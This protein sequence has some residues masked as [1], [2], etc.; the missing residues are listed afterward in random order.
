MAW[1]GREAGVSEREFLATGV[2]GLA[3]LC[4]CLLVQARV[5]VD[6]CPPNVDV[7]CWSDFV[8]HSDAVSAVTAT[9]ASAALSSGI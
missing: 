5:K 4:Y 2:L 7:G 8:D 1:G 9:V 6:G 3:N